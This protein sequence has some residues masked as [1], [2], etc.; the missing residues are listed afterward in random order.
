MASGSL[1]PRVYSGFR[2]VD[3]RGEEI[4]LIRSP[5]ALNMWKDYTKTD[6]ISTRPKLHVP[7]YKGYSLG[8]IYGIYQY[9][10][11]LIAHI[12]D[13]LK[14]I[15]NGDVIYKGVSERKS[16]AFIFDGIWYFKDGVNYLRYTGDYL[17]KVNGGIYYDE[18]GHP[19]YDIKEVEGYVPTTLIER[20]I[21]TKKEP[22]IGGSTKQDVNLLTRSRWNTF[23]WDGDKGG[24]GDEAIRYCHL[25]SAN[26]DAIEKLEWF[27][28]AT[29]KWTGYVPEEGEVSV[30]ELLD[31]GIV[32]LFGVPFDRLPTGECIRIK[33]R[34]K[35][36]D[37]S[38]KKITNCTL[39]QTFDNRVFFSGNPKYPNLVWHCS[40]NDPTYCSDTDYY[41]EGT[42]KSAVKGMVAG[43]NALWV[44]KRPSYGD[45]TAFYHTPTID[46]EYGK[47]Y[48]N[49]HSSISVG[50]V[51]AAINFNDDIVFFSDK[52]MEGVSG[53][54]TTEQF[55]SHRS[56][57]V[58]R[59]LTAEPE[60]ENMILEEWQGY[61]V[62]IIGNK[63][64]LADSRAMFQNETHNEYEWF[65][66]EVPFE[67]TCA[68]VINEQMNYPYDKFANG[69]LVLCG[70]GIVWVLRDMEGYTNEENIDG[71]YSDYVLSSYWVTPKDKLGYPQYLKTTNKR[72]CSVEATGEE[73]SVYAKTEKD[74]GFTDD[75]LIGKYENVT[76]YFI[77][78]IKRKKFKD[79]QLKFASNKPFTLEM[80]TLE[81]FI[82]GY[83]K[84]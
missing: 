63:I 7:I 14:D 74:G 84:R 75:T 34:V 56:S 23:T 2:G 44:F 83:I 11:R 40:L 77:S 12:D 79:I 5:D 17:R 3:F 81:C 46:S 38:R 80:A 28:K 10:R 20:R 69:D 41:N 57:L 16:S 1:I 6:S 45:T 82:G 29:G 9:K 47:V 32:H 67:I 70:R 21:S 43:N 33:F 51:G 50:C 18:N 15:A 35:D 26:A 59:K 36:T 27:D 66:W 37:E 78:R 76:D 62:V 31:D 54:V 55:L 61:L 68:T 71:V 73:I 48:P 42:D 60:Y 19:L 8:T 30:Y 64:Y 22:G 39:L 25:D 53:D 52:G 49:T 4:N 65:Y 58:D 13:C 72:G 24:E